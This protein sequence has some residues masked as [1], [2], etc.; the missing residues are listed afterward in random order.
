MTTEKEN[1]TTKPTRRDVAKSG[2]KEEDTYQKESH[3]FFPQGRIF[4]ALKTEAKGSDETWLV[5]KNRWPEGQCVKI[6]HLTQIQD[7]KSSTFAERY[8][9]LISDESQP[10]THSVN[11]NMP[12]LKMKLRQYEVL[13]SDVY[14]D[15]QS[16]ENI[17]ISLPVANCGYLDTN[18]TQH[19][20][21]YHEDAYRR[22]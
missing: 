10:N 13:L 4:R 15:V 20:V 21:E 7:H 17:D 5:Y 14:V 22:G 12:P 11:S 1:E 2:E 3:N 19:F 16:S 9:P 6:Q 18:S 8:A